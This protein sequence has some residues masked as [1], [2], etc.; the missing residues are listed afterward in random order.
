[1]KTVLITCVGSGVGQSVVDSLKLVK[2]YKIIGADGTHNVYAKSFCHDFVI[3]SNMTNDNYTDDIINICLEKKVDIVIPGHDQELLI[4]SKNINKFN[5]KNLKVLVSEPRIIEISRNKQIWHDFFVKNGCKIVPTYSLK[6]YISNP[7]KSFLPAIVKP[8]GGSASQGISIINNIEELKNLNEEDI[9]Q[10]YLFPEKTDKNYDLI[11]KQVSKGKFVQMS[12]ISIQLLFSTESKLKGIF[13]SKNT[14]KNGVPIFIDPID[15][16]K[17]KYLNEILN[18]IPVLE[19]NKVC[20]PVNLQGR[21]TDKGLYFFEMNMRFTGITGNRA[22]LGFNEVDYLIKNFLGIQNVNKLEGFSFNKLG[23]RQVACT[24]I[25]RLNIS[26]SQSTITIFGGGS[27]IGRLFVDSI[28]NKFKKINL[29]VRKSSLSKYE[30]LFDNKRIQFI[31]MESNDLQ[32]VLCRTD[33]F[34]NFTSALAYE[35]DKL[36]FDAIRNVYKITEMLKH[37]NIDVI[38]N[39]SSQS[40]YPQNENVKKNEDFPIQA[41]TAYSFQKVIIEEFFENIAV[42]VPHSKVISLRLPRVIN[43]QDIEYCGYFGK[44]VKQYLNNE[45]IIINYPNNN[46]NLI[47]VLDVIDAIEFVLNN[48]NNLSNYSVFNVSGNNESIKDYCFVIDSTCN[49]GGSFTYGEES[50][51]NSSSMIDGTILEKLGWKRKYST[52]SIVKQMIDS[53]LLK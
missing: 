50:L 27:K 40:V 12:E 23:V 35:P 9:I 17:F 5:S 26:P 52:L 1:M 45:Q 31:E 14:L 11:K 51:M 39:I 7:D 49:S 19:I 28:Y 2:G 33:F 25:P 44:L 10:P 37:A 4:F 15:P 3:S 8:A 46:T 16:K 24:T 21:I 36:K 53:I 48:K 38:I 34:V 13:I 41:D 18:F 6:D 32:Q 29:I 30:S 20:G 47:H 22:L 42:N 43:P